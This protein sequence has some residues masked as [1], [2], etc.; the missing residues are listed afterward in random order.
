MHRR[1]LRPCIALTRAIREAGAGGG[2]ASVS[3]GKREQWERE[4]QDSA[5]AAATAP[6]TATAASCSGSATALVGMDCATFDRVLVWL[7]ADALGRGLH[8]STSQLNLSR[9]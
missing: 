3:S 2:A 5:P 9:F 7:E 1:L 8:S 6:A 4:H